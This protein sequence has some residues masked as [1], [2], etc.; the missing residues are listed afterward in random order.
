MEKA[1]LQTSEGLTMDH[2]A[3]H[4]S[5]SR[6]A[7]SASSVEKGTR[8]TKQLESVI[9]L[10]LPREQENVTASAP[11]KSSI[12]PVAAVPSTLFECGQCEALF[13]SDLARSNHQKLH[14]PG[15]QVETPRAIIGEQTIQS[16]EETHS[17]IVSSWKRALSSRRRSRS[18][19]SP[20]SS[21]SRPS[22]PI[23]VHHPSYHPL[24][25]P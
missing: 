1:L 15:D 11:G 17:V 22:I 23:K 12:H 25:S 9:D 19:T 8:T 24:H 20:S 7:R 21:R 3:S 16:V 14:Q 5:K 2:V 6:R 4:N 18:K 10:T 13:R